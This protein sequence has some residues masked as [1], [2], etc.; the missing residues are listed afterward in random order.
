V[1]GRNQDGESTIVISAPSQ[2]N[3]AAIQQLQ[4]RARAAISDNNMPAPTP[5]YPTITVS[6]QERIKVGSEAAAAR[7]IK[8][9]API[10]PELAKQARVQ[11]T[12]HLAAVIAQ[13]GTVQ[14]LHSIGGPALLIQAAMDAAKS[15]VFEPAYVNGGPVSVETTIDINFSLN[16]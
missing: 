1:S 6:S 9:T 4:V 11:G 7:I 16:Q 15:W 5:A 14:E 3:L 13:D 8:K 2:Q 12:V 10:Y